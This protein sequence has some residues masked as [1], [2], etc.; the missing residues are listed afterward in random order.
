MSKSKAAAAAGIVTVET[1]EGPGGQAMK[2]E[3]KA[4]KKQ[5]K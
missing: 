3:K 2:D 4:K 5:A 1:K